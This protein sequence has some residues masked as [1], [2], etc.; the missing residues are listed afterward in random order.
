MS[1]NQS[2]NEFGPLKRLRSIPRLV[3]FGLAARL[4][5]D[6]DWGIW[7]IQP[8]HYR[9]WDMIKGK[10]LSRH[11]HGQKGRFDAKL[12]LAEMLALIGP[13]TPEVTQQY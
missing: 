12:H 13:P 1:S 7:P 2:H 6:D 8:D 9:L 11:I 3:N 10:E 4:E 5:A